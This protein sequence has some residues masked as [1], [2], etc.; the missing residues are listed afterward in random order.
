[1]MLLIVRMR[2]WLGRVAGFFRL[3]YASATLK[4]VIYPPI[5]LRIV[6][7]MGWLTFRV[8]RGVWMTSSSFVSDSACGSCQSWLAG[9]V[10]DTANSASHIAG[11]RGV[12]LVVSHSKV[13]WFICVTLNSVYN[14]LYNYKH[15]SV[16]IHRFVKNSTR[17]I[18]I[19]Y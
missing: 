1:M 4:S 11:G 17:S 16:C 5:P 2:F 14:Y 15:Y 3:F 8:V 19:D 9:M 12:F 10:P 6:L 18:K 13:P 7:I